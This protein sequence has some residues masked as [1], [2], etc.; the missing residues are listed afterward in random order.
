M[1]TNTLSRFAKIKMGGLFVTGKISPTLINSLLDADELMTDE[2]R[3]DI[4]LQKALISRAVNYLLPLEPARI[5]LTSDIA[6]CKTFKEFLLLWTRKD[7]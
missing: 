1:D 7:S 6:R 5:K 3:L 4:I 2:D